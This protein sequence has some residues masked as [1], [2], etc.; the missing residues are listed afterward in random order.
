MTEGIRALCML[1]V[2]GA[3][4][5]SISKK[6]SREFRFGEQK[7]ILDVSDYRAYCEKLLSNNGLSPVRD[8]EEMEKFMGD[9]IFI[10]LHEKGMPIS[11]LIWI[12]DGMVQL[13]R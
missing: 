10:I 3:F 6:A 2:V 1:E 12:G 8:M 7:V 9:V 11:A 5:E 13:I 4:M